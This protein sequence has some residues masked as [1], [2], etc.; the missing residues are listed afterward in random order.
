M[1]SNWARALFGKRLQSFPIVAFDAQ[2]HWFGRGRP[3]F[4][5]Q[6]FDLDAGDLLKFCGEFRNRPAARQYRDQ[7][8]YV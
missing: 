3:L 2:M 7:S 5:R 1:F 6:D 8:A 4:K